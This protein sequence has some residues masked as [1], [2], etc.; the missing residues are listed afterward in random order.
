MMHILQKVKPAVVELFQIGW[1]HIC[2]FQHL[3]LSATIAAFSRRIEDEVPS[4]E[5]TVQ[6]IVVHPFQNV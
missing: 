6:K 4:F 3:L 5:S 1:M 2:I